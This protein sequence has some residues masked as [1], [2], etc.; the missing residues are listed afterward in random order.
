MTTLPRRDLCLAC[1]VKLTYKRDIKQLADALPSGAD[2]QATQHRCTCPGGK[3]EAP[4]EEPMGHVVAR[5]P[6]IAQMGFPPY[7]HDF[8]STDTGR[9]TRYPFLEPH[10]PRSLERRTHNG[11]KVEMNVSSRRH[12]ANRLS[13][14]TSSDS[15]GASD[16]ILLPPIDGD[17]SP[18]RH[19]PP[20]GSDQR[21]ASSSWCS[22]PIEISGR[23]LLHSHSDRLSRVSD[24]DNRQRYQPYSRP[25]PLLRY[26]QVSDEQLPGN[27]RDD[28]TSPPGTLLGNDPEENVMTGIHRRNSCH[29]N[30]PPPVLD[31]EGGRR[32]ARLHD[33]FVNRDR[34]LPPL[35]LDREDLRLPPVRRPYRYKATLPE[36]EGYRSRHEDLPR[37]SRHQLPT[38]P[39][40]SS[41]P[42]A[43]NFRGFSD[44]HRP[45][46]SS[47]IYQPREASRERD[48]HDVRATSGGLPTPVH[49]SPMDQ[50]LLDDSYPN[51]RISTLIPFFMLSRMTYGKR[52]RNDGYTR[53]RVLR[54]AHED[55]NQSLLNSSHNDKVF[56]SSTNKECAAA[57]RSLPSPID[58]L[59]MNEASF[60]LNHGNN[61]SRMSGTSTTSTASDASVRDSPRRRIQL[62]G[63]HEESGHVPQSIAAVPVSAPLQSQVIGMSYSPP[64]SD[65][66]EVDQLSEDKPKSGPVNTGYS[67]FQFMPG[68]TT[69]RTYKT[70]FYPGDDK[71]SPSTPW[72]SRAMLALTDPDHS[73]VYADIRRMRQLEKDSLTAVPRTSEFHFFYDSSMSD[74][75]HNSPYPRSL[76]FSNDPFLDSYTVEIQEVSFH[77]NSALEAHD[78]IATFTSTSSTVMDEDIAATSELDSLTDDLD[79]I[80]L[81]PRNSDKP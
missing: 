11:A 53:D 76:L 38:P 31:V 45:W 15:S 13:P 52:E 57:S 18:W 63:A 6:S 37:L 56:G 71:A 19:L 68:N 61:R 69:S 41:S 46:R 21:G 36:S 48:H 7:Q 59:P 51:D 47:L 64:T 55:S 67:R 39:G 23:S 75:V 14:T 62:D 50:A 78:P 4:P 5:H 66:E 25:R 58:D 60:D 30:P 32:S 12:A 10:P 40:S 65:D 72:N 80:N 81:D 22:S 27:F 28:S 16:H 54:D 35:V 49:D 2:V 79:L 20:A 3:Y 29:S 73:T 1:R 26:T 77:D 24:T 42:L 43:P 17:Y 33:S 8:S 34:K 9:R 70:V 74:I 44:H